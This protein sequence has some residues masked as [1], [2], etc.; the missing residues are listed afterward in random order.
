[1][2]GEFFAA[3][4]ASQLQLNAFATFSSSLGH[5]DFLGCELTLDI[6]EVVLDSFTDDNKL[7]LKFFVVAYVIHRENVLF[8]HIVL[9]L[10]LRMVLIL[11][12]IPV[13]RSTL[14]MVFV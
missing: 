2:I 13:V 1:M 10:I 12:C 5:L 7:L 6:C 14:L 3:L 4:I 9:E 8:D 11:N